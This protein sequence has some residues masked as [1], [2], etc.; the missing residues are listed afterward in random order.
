MDKD[1]LNYTHVTHEIPPVFNSSSQILI[2]GSFPS[3]KSREGCFFYHHPQNR[4][5]KVISAITGEPLPETIDNK[6]ALL[7]KHGIAVWDVIA[8][9]DIYGSSDSSIKNAVPNDIS[10]ILKKAPIESIYSNGA[11]SYNLYKKYLLK[12]TGI[13]AVKLPSTSPANAAC[14]LEKLIKVWG[15]NIKPK[16]Q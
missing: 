3:V 2:L 14:S 9:C 5:W 15:E 8:S 1:L 13:E 12:Q 6:K 16:L 10:V 4:F 7:L 11:T